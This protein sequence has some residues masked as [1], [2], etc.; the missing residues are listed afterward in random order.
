[1]LQAFL[2]ISQSPVLCVNSDCET[3]YTVTSFN[4]HSSFISFN[5]YCNKRFAD[6]CANYFFWFP[7][8]MC[9][10]FVND[11]VRMIQFRAFLLGLFTLTLLVSALRV[12]VIL[13]PVFREN[14]LL[15]ILFVQNHQTYRDAYVC[16][17]TKLSH[18]LRVS[19]IRPSVA[20][21]VC[22]VT[23]QVSLQFITLRAQNCQC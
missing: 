1:M 8:K 17:L 23:K 6:H 18:Q 13:G 15:Y 5:N 2:A 3:L 4:L 11:L 21:Q 10:E 16:Q 19:H 9:G 7:C 12:G 22:I 14:S 20:I